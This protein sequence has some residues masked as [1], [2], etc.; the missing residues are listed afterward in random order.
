MTFL[1]D[2]K[3]KADDDYSKRSEN[4]LGFNP[5]DS[6]FV[7]VTPRLWTK[8]G[9]WIEEKRK[10]NIWKEIKVIDAELL[11]EWLE[12][13]PTVSAWLAIKH[14]GKYP[15][16]GIQS[17]ED[18]WEEWSSGPKIKL[19]SKLLLSGRKKE[20]DKLFEFTSTPSVTAIQGASR[21][22]SLA[23]MIS[24]FKNDPSKEEDFFARSLIVDNPET[25]RQL[26]VHNN[27]LILI[28]RFDDTGIINRAIAKC[29]TVIFPIGA[30]STAN[31]NNKIVLSKLDRD[32]FVEAFGM[33]Q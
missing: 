16:E 20:V 32:S 10:D 6:T 23:F 31:W 1:K 27:P 19:N 8:S 26:S 29:H 4:P 21:E 11:E 7:F 18:F 24:C 33:C 12:I 28:P 2:P 17:T 5:S 13:A 30:D 3:G 25:F 15:S 22:E 14:L 9:K